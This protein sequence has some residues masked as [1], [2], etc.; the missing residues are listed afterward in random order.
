M[1]GRT[2]KALLDGE[3]VK[4]LE[5]A[6]SRRSEPGVLTTVVTGHL[7]QMRLFALRQGVEFYPKRDS[8][9]FRRIFLENLVESNEIDSRL[10]GILDD[11]LVDGVGLWFFRPVGDSYRILWFK[12]GSY[13]AFYDVNDEIDVLELIYSYRARRQHKV[14]GFASGQAPRLR[15]IGQPEE[16]WVYVKVTRDTIEET[17][18]ESKPSFDADAML[19]PASLKT[20]RL[21]NGLGFIPAIESYNHV[22]PNGKDAVGE[23]DAF[24]DGILTHN[25]MVADIASNVGFY[26]SPTLL[27]S[28][29][30]RDLTEIRGT[31]GGASTRPSIRAGFRPADGGLILGTRAERALGRERVPKVIPNLEPN[32]RVGYITPNSVSGDQLTFAKQFREEIRTSL[33]GV[34]ELGISSGATAY[35]VRS[36]F[37]R[38][39]AT[40]ARKCR[41]L[42]DYGLCKLLAMIVVHEERIFRES[43]AAAIELPMPEA[44]IR[45][46]LLREE[47]ATEEDYEIAR[48][49]YEQDFAAWEQ[50]LEEEVRLAIENQSI[51]PGVVGLIPDGDPRVEWRHRGPV[52]EDSARDLLN[53]TIVC[54]NLQELGI[55]SIDALR[56]IF[57]SKTNEEL[58]AMLNGYPFRVVAETN[59]SIGMLMGL[60]N[61]MRQTPHP[62][63]LD[64]PLITDARL[65]LTP[66]LYRALDS[67][68]R[69][70]SHGRSAGPGAGDGHGPAELS[71]LER[72]RAER[73]LPADDGARARGHA[74]RPDAGGPGQRM[75]GGPAADQRLDRD[76][77]IPAPGATLDVDPAGDSRDVAA[78]LRSVSGLPAAGYPELAPTSADL[79]AGLPSAYRSAAD[80][81]AA[82]NA[83]GARRRGPARS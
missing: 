66:T 42:F 18:H 61:D 68:K 78:G 57:P 27:S 4:V 3:F 6:R 43:F 9:G 30:R 7:A 5:A 53:N 37:G 23:F 54:R 15:P 33:G 34:D 21:L 80:A 8:Y 73:G 10:D 67:L 83:A 19:A 55:G 81:L 11:L 26:G 22:G 48:D 76:A 41:N 71:A 65:D 16:K 14:M 62:Q 12:K 69:E 28:R 17:L 64:V 20:R 13:R 49:Q 39:A 58:S 74:F 56:H 32:D 31:P 52:F 75:G 44:P 2:E 50:K 72:A 24:A 45:E 47:G 38:A 1:P 29:P 46:D 79:L 70:L 51:P 60:I 82:A 63:K 59:K 77:P 25:E 35:E 40:A 36:L